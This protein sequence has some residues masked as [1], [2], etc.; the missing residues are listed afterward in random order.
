[1]TVQ[2]KSYRVETVNGSETVVADD[3]SFKGNFTFFYEKGEETDLN[4]FP[5]VKLVKGFSVYNV[6]SVTPIFAEE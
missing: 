5:E 6:V 2:A 4:P 1:M 3:W